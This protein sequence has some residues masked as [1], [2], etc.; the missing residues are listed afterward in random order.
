MKRLLQILGAGFVV[1]MVLAI[2]QE[3][4]FFA[5]AWFGKAEPEMELSEE[6]REGAIDAVRLT[7]EL[8]RHLYSSDGDPRFAERMPASERVVEALMKDVDYLAN[9][10]RRQDNRLQG[11]E[12]VGARALDAERA[13][14]RT[15]EYWIIGLQW[16]DGSVAA[17]PVGQLVHARYLVSR[18]AQG[19]RV[20]A[21]ELDSPE[22]QNQEEREE[23][24]AAAEEQPA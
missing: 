7:L 6:D 3:W 9:N 8:S 24:P 17:K 2:G 10:H 5:S 11:V 1:F 18:G 19:W 16:L 15:R 13:E 21:W 22:E 20:E 4:E 14:V 12:I 23:E